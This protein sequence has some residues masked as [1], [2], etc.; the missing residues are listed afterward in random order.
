[1]HKGLIFSLDVVIAA[2]ILLLSLSLLFFS[3]DAFAWENIRQ[4]RQTEHEL[5]A[6]A[7]SEIIVKNRNE[8]TPWNGA[9]YFDDAKK[10]VEQNVLDPNLLRKI[11]TQKAGKY[12]L[13]AVYKR[14]ALGKEYYFEEETENCLVV[15]RFVVMK[16]LI[17]E[18]AV[19]GVVVC[20]K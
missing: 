13:S 2:M 11:E 14:T 7:L 9:A 5:F 17:E 6:L 1:M 18:K 8:E 19:L 4:A 12:F 10:R 20:E 15:E 3:L 16:G